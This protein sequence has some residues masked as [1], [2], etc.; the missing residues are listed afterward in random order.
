MSSFSL[1]TNIASLSAQRRLSSA[2]DRLSQSLERLSSGLRINRSS[3]DPAGQ[4]VAA[5]LNVDK[6]VYAQGARNVNDGISYL[7]V[8]ESAVKEMKSILYRLGELA[9]QASNGTLGTSQRAALDEEAQVLTD[10]YNRILGIA[11][12]NNIDVLASDATELSVQA[13]YG[14][15]GNITLSLATTINETLGDG[16][17]QAKS[18][19]STGDN[20]TET[21][22]G[23]FNGDGIQDIATTN[24]VDD[25][26]GLFLGNGDGTFQAQTT[27]AVGT[28]PNAI[29]STDFNG[30]GFLDIVTANSNSAN[31]SILLGNGDGTFQASTTYATTSSPS[32]VEVGDLNGDG[33]Q[34]IMTGDFS[35]NNVSVLLGNGDGTFQAETSYTVATPYDAILADFN[36]DGV[37]DIAASDILSD[38]ISIFIGNGNGT[39]QA[40]VGFASGSEPYAIESGDFNDDGY[41]DLVS[42]DNGGDLSIYMG[43]GDGTFVSGVTYATG[44]T[45]RKVSVGDLNGDGI[46]DLFAGNANALYA[47]VFLGNGDGTF[48]AQSTYATDFNTTSIN[49]GDLNNDGV[50]DVVTTNA[51]TDTINVF[52]ANTVSTSSTFVVKPLENIDLSTRLKS[53]ATQTEVDENIE[54]LL[55][56]ESMVGAGLSR[57]DFATNLLKSQSENYAIAEGLILDVDYAEEATNMI[58]SQLVQQSAVAVLAQANQQSS[59]VLGL[60]SDQENTSLNNNF[61]SNNYNNLYF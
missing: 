20:P 5:N 55:Q 9:T 39:F 42:A 21:T 56:T 26:V 50:I 7:N 14:I 46:L 1:N 25:T 53:L 17:L 35:S 58:V 52:L 44:G 57:F 37:L 34:D 27:L 28:T 45:P 40:A 12:F 29:A 19:Y 23:D 6:R 4:A 3:D 54:Y 15:N 41:V 31:V 60:I 33:F 10:E 61:A 13:G 49:V 47:G 30:D 59:L 8:A 38:T 22:I 2:T 32:S 18:D 24:K 51:N 48:Q 43:N 11:E 36:D 16:T